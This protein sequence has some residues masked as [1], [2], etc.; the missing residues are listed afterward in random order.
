MREPIEGLSEFGRIR[1]GVDITNVAADFRPVYQA[2]AAVVRMYAPTASV[3][4]YGSVVTGQARV[5]VSDVD[6]LTIGLPA[7]DARVIETELSTRFANV[8]RSVE[9]VAAQSG[10]FVGESDESYGK[11]PRQWSAPAARSHPGQ[12]STTLDRSR[13][14]D[15]PG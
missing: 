15:E 12:R 8:C 2:V 4:A 1:T 7:G 6:L 10:D 5:G 11:C 13:R 3:Y 9:I 14:H